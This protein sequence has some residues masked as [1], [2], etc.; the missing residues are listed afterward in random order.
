[1]ASDLLVKNG[2]LVTA[3]DRRRGDLRCRRGRIV[4][5][6]PD[7]EPAGEELI[8]ASGRLVFP[9]GVDP[10]V[11]LSLPVMGTVSA[12]DFES[13]TAAA[14]AGG[15]TTVIDFVHPE[16]GQDL[17]EALTERKAEAA[18]AVADWSLHMA[19][20]W[21]GDSTAEWMRRCAVEEGIPSFKTY[22]AYRET[23]GIGDDDL[24]RVMDCAA[25]ID[26]LVIVHAEHDA[27]ISYLRRRLAAEGRSDAAAHAASRP[28]ETEG[29]AT[30]RAAMM[31]AL[32]GS[33]LYVFH[34]TC[35]EA[36][37][38][39][40]A[41]RARGQ[42]LWAETCPHYLLLDDSLYSR[43]GVAGAAAVVAP[44]LRAPEHQEV[45]W[46]ALGGGDLQVV[47]TDHC[48]FTRAQKSAGRDDF[49]LIPGGAA[50]I[51]H[52]LA[53]LWT[54]GVAAGRIDEQRFVDLVSTT[55][56]RLF[57]LYPRKGTLEPGADA[58]LVIWD[59]TATATLSAATHHHRTDLSIFE[60]FEVR[61]LPTAVV[62]RG[63]VVAREG[64]LQVEPG[65][66]RFL[67]R[68]LSQ[69]VA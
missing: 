68:E 13:G 32:A 63:Q 14:L 29:E 67:R 48:P 17:M 54:Y 46:N 21:W 49:R 10:H 6:G 55:P 27:A 12:D 3:S 30:A 42:R 22:M 39:I 37:A 9:G 18:R 35:R 66:G 64:A 41:A 65:R 24:M 44:P 34:V 45:L 4:E 36:V 61:G 16:R 1:M 56:A 31:A 2:I 20:T 11:H 53:L 38:A 58:D 69:V 25:A 26:A 43:P 28:P 33:D 40:A 60:G 59:P 23:V 5:S 51:E 8:D 62:A 19:V 47:S 52:R 7:L 57:G 15:T 50:G